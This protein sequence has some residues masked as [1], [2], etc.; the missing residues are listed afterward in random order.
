MSLGL[1][2][3]NPGLTAAA[4][5]ALDLGRAYGLRVEVT[6]V[7]RSVAEQVGLRSRYEGCLARSEPVYPGNP[8]PACRYPA[9]RPGDSAH[10]WGLAWD[11][12]AP[13][14]Q[15]PSWVAIRRALGW[16]VPENDLIHAEVPEW[17]WYVRAA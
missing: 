7:Y 4:R 3:L 1:G 14:E 11:S 9:N 8:N 12:W 6:S 16:R 5:Y 13:P 17:R 10:N 2:G 15:M